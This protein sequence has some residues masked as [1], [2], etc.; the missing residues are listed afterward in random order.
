M[1]SPRF[2]ELPLMRSS[3]PVGAVIRRAGRCGAA[4]AA[5]AVLTM[6]TEDGLLSRIDQRTISALSDGRN[7]AG[8]SMAKAVSALA[9]PKLVSALL[10]AQAI[11]EAR[12][13]GWREACVPALTVVSGAMARRM[14]SQIVARPR[15]PEA[16]WLIEPEGFSL[17]S[18][19]TTL[20]ALAAGALA[21]AAGTTGM[22]RSA[23]IFFA[24]A[25]A[26]TSRIYLGVHW[27]SD[28]VAAWLFA[29]GWLSLAGLAHQRGTGR[30]SGT[31]AA[32]R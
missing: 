2:V 1:A 31:N 26:G 6:H 27:P 24:A 12:R 3:A 7:P 16:V 30:Q 23:A 32:S 10:A 19:H 13:D 20:A 4:F 18:K 21:D 17:P 29:E 25:A 5:L 22:R 9:E 28:V 14:L 11:P 8:I 15:P